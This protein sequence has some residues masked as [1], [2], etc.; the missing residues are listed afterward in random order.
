MI[1]GLLLLFIQINGFS[2]TKQYRTQ[3]L[4]YIDLDLDQFG[5]TSTGKT[6]LTIILENKIKVS[7]P[8]LAY[9]FNN[10]EQVV[11]SI[12]QSISSIQQHIESNKKQCVF[13][14]NALLYYQNTQQ[15][16]ITNN[17]DDQNEW[18]YNQ[19]SVYQLNHRKMRLYVYSTQ[20]TTYTLTIS[21]SEKGECYNSCN[22]RG[23]CS[24]NA[25]KLC[26]CQLGV[27]DSTC[28]M[29]S[30]I[31]NFR[32]KSSFQM[33]RQTENL[34][35][36]P[37]PDSSS[38]LIITIDSQLEIKLYYGCSY[39]KQYIPF[40]QSNS[41]NQT[42]ISNGNLMISEKDLQNC[43]ENANKIEEALETPLQKY[44]II[45]FVN[46]QIMNTE[47]KLTLT[48]GDSE[49]SD[50]TLEIVYIILCVLG[51]LIILIL[52]I[53][54]MI[55]K[56]R[57][58]KRILILQPSNEQANQLKLKKFRHSL[59]QDYIATEIYD[60]VIQEFPGL[61]E[62]SECQICLLQFKKQDLV[63]LTYCLHLFHQYCLDEWRKRTQTC[64]FCRSNLTQE[65]YMQQIQDEQII[66][67]GVVVDD[68]IQIDPLKLQEF[69]QREQRI[70]QLQ[71]K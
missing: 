8:L 32:S 60:Q 70:R 27:L 7:Y 19:Y 21:S 20:E 56:Q 39:Q 40:Y 28:Q 13:D 33:E 24:E 25:V 71:C 12:L 65:R 22:N 1:F 4:Q 18:V 42:N 35:I 69:Q 11:K 17:I 38:N 67:L 61:Q 36:V 52:L 2:V 44:L 48:S 45:L 9:C 41:F 10:D 64:P 66:R 3:G 46:E 26:Q 29:T 63:K 58:G 34:I 14:N 43:F 6:T 50:D 68:A 5:Q 37:L 16:V 49:E 51:S 59:R 53:I 55:Q 23:Y 57:K 62:S 30:N 47:I 54:C 15:L 31:I